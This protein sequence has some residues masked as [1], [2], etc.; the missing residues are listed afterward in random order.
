MSITAIQFGVDNVKLF[1][2]NGVAVKIVNINKTYRLLYAF[3]R[4]FSD[5]LH[6]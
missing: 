3:S 5:F 4:I 1:L 2:R 6:T